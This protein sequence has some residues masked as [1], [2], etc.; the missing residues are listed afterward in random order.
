MKKKSELT[1]RMQALLDRRS[2]QKAFRKA[3]DLSYLADFSSNDYL[4]LSRS[5]ALQQRIHQQASLLNLGSTGSRLLSGHYELLQTLENK[6]AH[7][8]QAEA[9]LLFNAG[10]N[11]NLSL[12]STLARRSDIILYD[13]LIH[14]SM[15]DGMQLSQA[16]SFPFAHND[17]PSLKN[18]LEQ[19]E[20][21]T[22]FVLVESIYSMDGDAAPLVQINQLCQEFK[23]H[24]IVDEAHSTGTFGKRGEGLCIELGIEK[25]VF[26]RVHTFGKAIGVHGAAVLGS[27]LLY[28]YLFNYA[29][30]F[31][32]TTAM[33]PHTALAVLNSYQELEQYGS[34]FIAELQQ[35]IDYFRSLIIPLANENYIDSHSAIQCILVAG[36]E[37]VVELSQ[38]LQ[39]KGFDA[40]PIRTPTVPIGKERIR[41]CLHRH[42]SLEEIKGIVEAIYL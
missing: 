36:N 38:R 23:A 35:K 30:A 3:Q 9:A 29:R 41:F 32:Y 4:S 6:L 31:I 16:S 25:E 7:F 20:G 42:N 40:K 27:Q 33:T 8:H 19:H 26:A 18:L 34:L 39:K 14:A 22:V 28:D 10:Y 21:K 5:T 15:H 2:D 24:L 13:E 1:L 17:C 37:Q 11:A 12:L